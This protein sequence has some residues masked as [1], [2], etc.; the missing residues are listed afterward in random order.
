MKDFLRGIIVFATILAAGILWFTIARPVVVLPRIRL[1]PGYSLRTGLNQIITSEDR[2]GKLTLYSFAYTRCTSDCQYIY[3]NLQAIDTTLS[4]KPEQVPPLDFI[5]ITID[6]DW[7][8]QDRLAEFPLPFQPKAVNWDW[9]TGNPALV[10]NITATGF[11]LMYS[12][13]SE[14]RFVFSQYYVLVDGEG[15]IRSEFEGPEFT[16]ERFLDYLDILN[17]EISQS[18]GSSKLAYEAAHFFACYPH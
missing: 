6:P 16:P 14:G 12:P 13:L 3:S 7:D 17:K 5:T 2:R 11:E 4:S 8:T 15:I 10:Q 9:L 18:Q 1:A